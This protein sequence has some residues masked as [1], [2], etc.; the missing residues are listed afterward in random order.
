MD[1]GGWPS[2]VLDQVAQ[3]FP[4]VMHGVSLGI[5]GTDALNRAYL[6]AHPSQSYTLMELGAKF[7]DWLEA[8]RPDADGEPQAWS[9][10]MV[11]LARLERAFHAVYRG[12]G[13]EAAAACSPLRV[14]EM[15]PEAQLRPHLGTR[16][17][18]LRA[19][20][21]NVFMATRIGEQVALPELRDCAALLFRRRYRVQM[22][23]L[24][25]WQGDAV[26]QLIDGVSIAQLERVFAA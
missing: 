14:A 15:G 24:N 17:L 7:P 13:P 5:G 23:E 2:E 21:V 25:P 8:H 19:P 10:L 22:L 16:V 26:S 11:D 4:V 1:G 12:D 20:L 3:R 6:A 9:S 18:A